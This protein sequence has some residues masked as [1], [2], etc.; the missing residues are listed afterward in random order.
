MDA[1]HQFLA[2]KL[3]DATGLDRAAV[4][5]FLVQDDRVCH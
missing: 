2:Q 1:R 5:D 3:A 4:E